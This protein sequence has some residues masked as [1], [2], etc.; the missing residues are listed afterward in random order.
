MPNPFHFGSAVRGDAFADRERELEALTGF[1]RNGINVLLLSPRRYGK[2]SLTLRAVETL[3]REKGRAA[4]AD[5]ARCGASRKEFAD[6]L[7]TAVFRDAL[8]GV[9]G[10]TREL[11]R[12]LAHVRGSVRLEA[13]VSPEGRANFAV[14]L[15]P[16]T[17]E[18]DWRQEIS[19]VLRVLCEGAR[20]RPIALVIDEFQKVES[21]DPGLPWFFK[22]ITDELPAL[23]LVFAGSRRTF[24]KQLT[25]G[26][27]APFKDIGE[28]L[29]LGLIAEHAMT[30]FLRKRAGEAGK[31]MQVTAAARIFGLARG[32]PDFVQQLAY[33]SFECAGSVIDTAAVGAGIE[34]LM[35]H[36][37]AS[38]AEILDRRPVNQQ[39]LLKALAYE[40]ERQ[41]FS[42]AFLRRSGVAGAASVSKA[43]KPL[44]DDEL[45]E[46][47]PEGWRI[48]NP[49]FALWLR[50]PS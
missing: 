46:L 22:A 35:E 19:A 14:S 31:E 3:Q 8:G 47:S 16:Y 15:A 39:R 48:F 24:M 32:V 26:A 29:N 37:A 1:M 28:T 49:F 13:G 43:L 27:N 25:E 33:H 18:T 17:T 38:F 34:R 44:E 6:V 5:L 30:A 45:I 40:P 7:A 21:I 36:Q 2:S 9:R 50:Q 10:L 23:S 12:K 41:P 11:Q 4:R 20:N 42:A